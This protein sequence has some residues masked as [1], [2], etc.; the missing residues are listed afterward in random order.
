ML[1]PMADVRDEMERMLGELTEDWMFPAR[2]MNREWKPFWQNIREGAKAWIPAVEV[3]E[4]E[5]EYYIKAEIPG[6]KPDD[7]HVEVFGDT[8]VIQAETRQSKEEDKKH[9]HRSEMRYGRFYRQIPLPTQ[10]KSETVRAEFQHGILELYL[11]KRDEDQTRRTRI[12]IQ[13]KP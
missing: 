5:K 4:S 6:V 3:S 8:V 2:V 11:P 13:S 12:P 10:V 1:K 7:L 9:V